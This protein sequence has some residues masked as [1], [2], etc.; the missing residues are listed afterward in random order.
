MRPSSNQK[1]TPNG[2]MPSEDLLKLSWQWVAASS[3]RERCFEGL[4]LGCAVGE[5]LSVAR[6]RLS[7]RRALRM[8]GRK[9]LRYQFAA[10]SGIPS[11]RTHALLL[12]VQAILQ[13]R[14]D[15]RSFGRHLRKR[16]SWYRLG[17]PFRSLIRGFADIRSSSQI[18]SMPQQLTADPLIRAAAISLMIQGN[19]HANRWIETST[20]QCS[21]NEVA[22]ELAMLVGNAIQ[23]AQRLDS[24]ES[25]I[26]P[27]SALECLIAE[28]ESQQLKDQLAKLRPALG[29]SKSIASTAKSFGWIDGVPSSMDAIAIMA[30]YA[31]LRHFSRLRLAIEHAVLL[32]GECSAVAA[33]TGA[34]SGAT[35]GKRAIPPEW[36]DKLTFFPHDKSWRRSLM[37]R[38]KD[39]P[40]GVED[41][42]QA[43][44][45]PS[46][47]AGQI[48]RNCVFG[49]F[50]ALHFLLRI[51]TYFMPLPPRK[52]S[53]G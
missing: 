12:T 21:T 4:L 25:N 1:E 16:V 39:W 15:H 2:S 35:L 28:T 43:N 19:Q 14:A 3:R 10:G 37:S 8:F 9:P 20:K 29:K 40:H 53:R 50:S 6:N 13:S 18:V 42:Q 36:L 7:R 30:I 34:L 41:I 31:W 44:A 11:D 48:A 22:T 45:Q 27:M 49:C 38:V 46:Q 5:A 52:M 47:L 26:S 51:P 17:T 33:L 24:S 23:I 32:G